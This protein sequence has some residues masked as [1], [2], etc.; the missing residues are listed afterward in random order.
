MAKD[1]AGEGE[2]GE[3]QLN[4]DPERELVA[5]ERNPD[6]ELS[7]AAAP[8][9]TGILSNLSTSVFHQDERI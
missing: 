3:F 7:P 1:T 6:A 8:G 4:P 9:G 5:P 2:R